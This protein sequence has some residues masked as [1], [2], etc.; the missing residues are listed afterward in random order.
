MVCRTLA[1]VAFILLLAHPQ[2]IPP[3][4]AEKNGSK[5]AVILLD[6]SAS[7]NGWGHWDTARQ[8]LENA[9][10]E[11]Q[12]WQRSAIASAHG[13]LAELPPDSTTGPADFL[14]Q[15]SPTF[16]A[17]DH[18]EAIARAATRLANF[19]EAR[20]Y[21]I[22]DFRRHDWSNLPQLVP[23]HVAIHF[24]DCGQSSERNAGVVSARS[25]PL[26]GKRLRL[27]ITCRNFGVQP[28][29]RTLRVSVGS[30]QQSRDIDLPALAQTRVSFA[31]DD[32]PVQTATASLDKDDYPVDDTLEFA[33]R[34]AVRPR[35]VIIHPSSTS[36]EGGSTITETAAL[37]AGLALSPAATSEQ[38]QTTTHLP[39]AFNVTYTTPAQLLPGDLDDARVFF[40]LGSTEELGSAMLADLARLLADG[41]VLIAT[42]GTSPAMTLRM[43][44]EANLLHASYSGTA[45]AAPHVPL[46]VGWLAPDSPPYAFF[47]SWQDADL[48]LFPIK[49]HLRLTANPPTK[50][51]LRSLDKLPL[52]LESPV[53]AGKAYLFAFDFTPDWSAFPL[54]ASFLPMLRELTASCV[55]EGFGI[56]RLTCGDEPPAA[57]MDT[58]RPAVLMHQDWPVEI[59][60][61]YTESSTER[62]NTEDLRV[63]L[64]SDT[65]SGIPHELPDKPPSPLPAQC[66]TALLLLALLGGCLLRK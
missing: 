66:C 26:G 46:G 21:L 62:L 20:L 49:R 59:T 63:A 8:H 43:L 39:G 1:L 9:W 65:P 30:Q 38:K 14:R 53:G 23:A 2:W 60:P 35:A 57:G 64:T 18:R 7:M 3:K 33:V 48:F 32:S 4:T 34:T 13:V 47:Q 37:F 54:C 52:L 5:A 42:P 15:H 31:F 50:D 56:Y 22:S 36:T 27:V 17:A 25:F 51:L 29:R 24:L 40:L 41:R 6:C 45:T 11:T 55:P 12:G 10:K 58:S 19:T 16:L 44:H 61:P 28:E